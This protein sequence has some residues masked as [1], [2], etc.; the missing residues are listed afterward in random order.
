MNWDEAF[1]YA[2]GLVDT[3]YYKAKRISKNIKVGSKVKVLQVGKQTM[4]DNGITEDTVLTVERLNDDVFYCSL[5][6]GTYVIKEGTSMYP[7]TKKE[8]EVL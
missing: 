3:T 4:I 2:E 8:V 5:P 6:S 1:E 7:F